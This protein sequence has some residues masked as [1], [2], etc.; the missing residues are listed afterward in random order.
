MFKKSIYLFTIL[1]VLAMAG[2]GCKGLTAEQQAAIKPVTLNYWTVNNDLVLLKQFA[3]DY[4][5]TRPYVSI[6][7]EQVRADEFE[8]RLTNALADDVSPDIVSVDVRDLRNYTSRLS[9]MP[10]KVQVTKLYIKGTYSKETVV[11][12]ESIGLPTA[13][14]V[15]S[16]FISTVSNDA[17]IGGQIYGLPLAVDT[18]AIFYNKDLLDKVGVPEAPK[19]WDEFMQAVKA[20][21]RFNDKGDIIQ[22]GVA[23]GTAKNIPHS[24]DILSLL[25][26]QSGVKMAYGG[27]VNFSS[28]VDKS[29]SQHPAVTALR[30][31]TDFAQPTKDVYTWN[32]KMG[33]AFEEFARGKTVFYFGFA[34]EYPRLKAR[35]PQINVE[36]LPMLQL[37][38]K[39]PV[40]IANY[41]IESVVKKSKHPNEAWEFVAFMAKSENIKKYTEATHRPTPLRSQIKAQ[42]EDL[43]LAPF[44]SQAL[45]A[46]NWYRGRNIKVASDA[47]DYLINNYLQPVSEEK[48]QFQRDKELLEYTARLVQQT[49]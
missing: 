21:T 40:N 3:A 26:M 33:D 19:N 7:I 39:Q 37:N 18:M 17:I 9:E 47:F 13:N 46:E 41:W 25:M 23:L 34:Y 4:K 5:K 45:N 11:E 28:G 24:F 6:N 35:A 31:Y 16:A 44:A 43:T 15:K 8:K 27:S 49:M 30:F 22:S 20:S 32:D 2:F 38:D 1:S 12:T 29:G 42:S 14:S 36:V 48:S 10:A